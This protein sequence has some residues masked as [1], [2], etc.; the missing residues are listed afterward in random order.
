MLKSFDSQEDVPIIVFM[1]GD[2]EITWYTA[3]VATHEIGHSLS[4]YHD[5][6]STAKTFAGSGTGHG[7]GNLNSWA[8]IMGDAWFS[9]VAQWS[10][11][12]YLDANNLQDDIAIISSYLGLRPDDHG[13]ETS[14]ATL[15]TSASAKGTTLVWTKGII[16]TAGQSDY[17]RIDHG[18]GEIRAALSVVLSEGST[19]L[20][21]PL[22]S[23]VQ[24]RDAGGNVLIT[25]PMLSPYNGSRI[26]S[27]EQ[28][29]GTYYLSVTSVG[30][31]D[32]L[33]GH[34]DANASL[35]LVSY[36]AIRIEA[37]RS[38]VSGLIETTTNLSSG[39]TSQTIVETSNSQDDIN[40]LADV[41]KYMI[42][43]FIQSGGILCGSTISVVGQE[44][45]SFLF[46]C[47]SGFL[48]G[49]LLNQ[50]AE[51]F[52]S[53]I[54]TYINGGSVPCDGRISLAGVA[55]PYVF[56]C[57]GSPA[58]LDIS[59]ALDK[60]HNDTK[61]AMLDTNFTRGKP[62]GVKPSGAYRVDRLVSGAGQRTSLPKVNSILTF[63]AKGGAAEIDGLGS[64][65]AMSITE[66][67]AQG[68]I[69]CNSLVT[70]MGL[71]DPS[72]M[73]F[74]C[75]ALNFINGN[76]V[77]SFSVPNLCCDP[78]PLLSLII[79]T[80]VSVPDTLNK[81]QLITAT[82]TAINVTRQ[83]P[84]TPMEATNPGSKSTPALGFPTANDVSTGDSS[85]VEVVVTGDIVDD[86]DALGDTFQ[87]MIE[88]YIINAGLRC[89]STIQLR[90]SE[91]KDPFVV[92]QCAQQPRTPGLE[93]V[94]SVLNS[95]C[96]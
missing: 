83:T 78:Q 85:A 75:H 46:Q 25:A 23:Q 59:V 2:R 89:G 36:A 42:N 9:N 20:S 52:I 4:L 93:S 70:I 57:S 30:F 76:G 69:V 45:G 91:D 64:Y 92:Y 37:V 17:F 81:A 58:L 50:F 44:G 53:A 60:F 80:T 68:K 82:T 11:G 16:S 24:L 51:F 40:G 49:Y 63:L 10:K 61:P 22:N 71:I 6:S 28:S 72:M 3:Q 18:G 66:L 32:A 5:G 47:N 54:D 55:T 73:Q 95:L 74:G 87:N 19:F 34:T 67:V 56:S 38:G 31:G 21:A 27:T 8:P 35:L 79:T 90:N 12:E 94:T 86:R 77:A 88:S 26:P 48:S 41:F 39:P 15:L 1:N 96:C 29:A 62:T 65:V 33:N 43:F 14:T 7:V 13:S 84:I